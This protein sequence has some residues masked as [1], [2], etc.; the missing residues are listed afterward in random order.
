M[1]VLLS[2]LLLWMGAEGAYRIAVL[3]F[4]DRTSFSGPWDIRVEIPRILVERIGERGGYSVVSMDTVVALLERRA[5]K[6][7]KDTLTAVGRE[8]DVDYLIVGSIERFSLSRFM[9]GARMLGGYWSYSSDVELKGKLVRA[10]DGRVMGELKGE[11]DVNDRDLGLSLLGR[12]PEKD[13]QFYGIGELKFGSEEF[14]RT[15]LGR[16]LEEAIAG[17]VTELGKVLP[18]SEH[19]RRKAL[20]VLVEDGVVYLNL[21]YEDGVR[22]GDRFW[23]YK[24]GEIIRDPVTGEVLGRADAKKVGEVQVTEVK[25]PHLSKAR[26]VRGRAEKGNELRPE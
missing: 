19:L 23:V 10:V 13:R 11:G 5:E 24:E 12:R 9:V 1:Q 6:C 22:P 16:A 3:P 2:V 15:I 17:F 4:E 26:L 7:P 14:R 20:V 25:A 21:G 18:A 8:L